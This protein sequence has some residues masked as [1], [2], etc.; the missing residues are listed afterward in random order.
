MR[1]C[2]TSLASVIRQLNRVITGR[3]SVTVVG[4]WMGTSGCG[5]NHRGL[6]D[7]LWVDIECGDVKPHQHLQSAG[8]GE[9]GGSLG[10]R[11]RESILCFLSSTGSMNL[12][13][14]CKHTEG[15]DVTL[16]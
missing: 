3:V 8:D 4:S 9:L 5:V 16:D 1:Q 6:L 10:T 11:C 12:H 14:G 7:G 2:D 15:L 13:S